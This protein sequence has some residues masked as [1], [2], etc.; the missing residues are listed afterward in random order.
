MPSSP[1]APAPITLNEK[2]PPQNL[3]AEASVLG[4]LLI[5]KEAISRIADLIKPDDFYKDSNAMVF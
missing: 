3:E 2:I 5:D 1:F 4:A